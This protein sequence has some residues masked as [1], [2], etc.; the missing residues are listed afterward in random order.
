MKRKEKEK[1]M[2][3]MK[4]GCKVKICD[5]LYTRSLSYR[6]PCKWLAR[7]LCGISPDGRSNIKKCYGKTRRL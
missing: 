2:E 5:D 3:R 6:T 7:E 1:Q 4:K